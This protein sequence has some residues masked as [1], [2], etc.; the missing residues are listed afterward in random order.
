MRTTPKIALLAA[1]LL[2]GFASLTFAAD[3]PEAP[4]MSGASDSMLAY[5]CAGCHAPDG[6]SVGPA[7]PVI[8]GISKD[9]FIELMEGFAKGDVPSTIMGRIAQGYTKEEVVQMADFF[10]SKP[11]VKAKQD[12]DKSLVK[13]GAKLHDKYCEKCH[14]EGGT[15]AEDDSGILAGQWTP[16]LKWSMDDFIAGH[17]E[18]TKKMK[19]KVT[20][21]REK[22]GDKG[23]TALLNYY[24]SQQ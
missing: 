10:G 16:Y 4:V 18:M 13:K 21:M 6:A 3:K 22:E 24:A 11:F 7:T 5:T 2:L 19:K 20:K 17:R 14:A 15:L 8:A 12:F 9:Y 23:F 1:G